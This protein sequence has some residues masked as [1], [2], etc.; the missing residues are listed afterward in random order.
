M[1]DIDLLVVGLGPGGGSAALEAARGGVKVLGIEKNRRIGEPVQCAEF[2]PTPLGGHA[3]APGVRVQTITGM[4]STLP[5]GT[6]VATDFPGLMV[7]RARFDQAIARRAEQAGAGLWTE[8]RLCRLDPRRRVAVIRRRD[9]EQQIRYRLLIAADGP[10]STTAALLGLPALEVVQ[11]RQ[12]TVPLRV[13]YRDTDIWLSDEF[14]GGY[15]W[16][17]P[18]G[19]VANLGIGAD[20][21]F[22][23]D[24][25]TPLDR[26]HAQLA[27]TGVVGAEILSRTGGAIPVGGLRERLVEDGVMFVGDAAGLTHPISGAGIAAAVVS[28]ERAGRAA[29]EFLAGGEDALADFE[30]DVRDQFQ[31]TLERALQHRARLQQCWRTPLAH[32]DGVMRR[33]WIAFQEYFAEQAV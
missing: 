26:L 20:R 3:R 12:Y 27:R 18:K 33:G 14:P 24:L 10:H 31:A 2:I 29:A 22:E 17:F 19:E 1:Q 30:E 5:S 23:P 8:A 7:D 4:K 15:G 32:D 9:Q 21:R 25:K 6:V 16:L 28:G 13:P 11:T